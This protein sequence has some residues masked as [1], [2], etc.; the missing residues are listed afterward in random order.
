[1][2]HK[3]QIE[4]DWDIEHE[5]R[6]KEAQADAKMHGAQPFE[7]DRKILKDVVREKMGAEV[8]K[9]TFLS[10]GEHQRAALRPNGLLTSDYRLTGTFHKV[11]PYIFT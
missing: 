7:V 5:D 8:G 11:R 3:P 10:S 1:M 9:I 2:N 6:R 4:W